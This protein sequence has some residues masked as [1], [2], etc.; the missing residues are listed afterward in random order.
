MSALLSAVRV[1]ALS[2][3][4]FAWAVAC[5]SADS[6]TTSGD[7]CFIYFGG[8]TPPDP[9]DG[10]SLCP[11]GTCNYQSQ[12]GCPANQTCFP[13][14]DARSNSVVATCGAVGTQKSGQPCGGEGQF[15]ARGL[16]CVDGACA[17]ACCGGDY[18]ACGA[19][20]SCIR[21]A[22]AFQTPSDAGVPGKVIA[23]D[24]GLGTCAPVGNCDLLN[25]T[26]CAGDTKRPVCRIVDPTGA[27]AC[28]PEGDRDVGDDCDADHQCHAGQHCAGNSD[29]STPSAVSTKCVKLCRFG[30]C[31]GKPACGA[32]EG[33]CVHFQRDPAGVGE[34]TPNWAGPGLEVDGGTA[35][36]V[37]A[38]TPHSADAA[39]D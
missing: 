16:I 21:Q 1:T 35:S 13:H 18:S 29:E 19:G 39:T 23:Y 32:S 36:L 5:G 26:S 27:V 28:S 38:G 24:E 25:S 31:T 20:E 4:A 10:A 8:G 3:V 15:C 17:K 37:E 34:C 11:A 14:Y 12:Q 7:R 9:P 6:A 22:V 2:G 33:F 30:D